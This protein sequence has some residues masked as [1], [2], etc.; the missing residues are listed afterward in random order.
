LFVFSLSI[1]PSNYLSNALG[2][3]Y[4]QIILVSAVISIPFISVVNFIFDYLNKS[5]I[6]IS[7]SIKNENNVILRSRLIANLILDKKGLIDSIDNYEVPI[8][9]NN[10]NVSIYLSIYLSNLTE[11]NPLDFDS[12]YLSM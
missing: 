6:E 8:D 12:F 5:N 4:I 2:N 10:Q 11:L 1:H 7:N 9:K 3:T